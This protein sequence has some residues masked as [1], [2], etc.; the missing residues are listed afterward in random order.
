[1]SRLS[2]I[3]CFSL[4]ST[5]ESYFPST[6]SFFLVV[7]T[8]FSRQSSIISSSL[9]HP[10]KHSRTMSRFCHLFHLYY[11]SLLFLL[12]PT[13]PLF[14]SIFIYKSLSQCVFENNWFFN[15]NLYP[16]DLVHKQA[17][18]NVFVMNEW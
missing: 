10:P 15:F 16:Y 17:S 18:N 7:A 12:S 11:L 6:T 13:F 4:L 8:H 1:M 14:L 2:V 3:L 9:K 5:L